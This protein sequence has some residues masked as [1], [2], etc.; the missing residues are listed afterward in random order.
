MSRQSFSLEV[1]AKDYG[2]EPTDTPR[3]DRS[4]ELLRSL[5]DISSVHAFFFFPS[6]F[7]CIS[8]LG[9][10]NVSMLE[11]DAC[12][13]TIVGGIVMVCFLLSSIQLVLVLKSLL[14]DSTNNMPH[15][16][17]IRLR[18]TVILV[19]ATLSYAPFTS[20]MSKYKFAVFFPCPTPLPLLGLL[21]IV[22]SYGTLIETY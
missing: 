6:L 22:M 7:I 11:T 9:K 16:E 17:Q 1:N 2:F 4:V 10:H 3:T 13:R 18:L 12:N 20:C 5:I 8:F 14:D 19:F 15:N 21:C